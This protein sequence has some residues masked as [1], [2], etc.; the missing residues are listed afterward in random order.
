MPAG[1]YRPRMRTVLAVLAV[2]V[3]AVASAQGAPSPSA[4]PTCAVAD[5]ATAFTGYDQWQWTLVDTHFRL[6]ADYAPPDLVSAAR[7]GL[8][9]DQEIRA[10]V[11]PAL[12][13]MAEAAAAAGHP[14]AVQSGYRSY[15]TQ[16]TTFQYWV[17]VDG[18]DYALTS[19]ARP[20]HSEHQL[21][22]AMDLRAQGGKAPWDYQDW[23]ATPTGGWVAANAWRYGFVMSYP[24]GHEADTCYMYEP[25]HYRYVGVD[26]ARQIHER[27]VTPRAFLWD[28]W[29][30]S[31]APLPSEASSPRTT[32]TV[33]AGDTLWAI[34]R[35][36]GT[37]VAE[38]RR[39]NGLDGDVIRVG[40]QLDVP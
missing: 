29:Q 10:I 39:L 14:I 25:W 35:R 28:H 17:K 4:L 3:A 36:Y 16:V 31:G 18:Y 27:G 5:V 7:A 6:P 24:N 38:I 20:G 26:A 2:G 22:I 30:A 40:M 8:N 12:K 1:W 21:G 33:R 9:G 32:V 19:S 37:T 34:A 13:A 23:A 11:V 15:Q